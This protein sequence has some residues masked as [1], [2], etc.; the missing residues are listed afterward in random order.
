MSLFPG[1]AASRTLC[2]LAGLC[3]S[4]TV[5]YAQGVPEP[6]PPDEEAITFDQATQTL[7]DELVQFNR[8]AQLA[9]DEFLYPPHSRLSVYISNSVEGFLLQE[10]RVVIDDGAPLV[11][12]YDDRDSRAL[13]KKNALQRLVHVNVERGA[14]RIKADFRGQR[15]DAKEG[16]P[17]LIGNHEAII[18]K[19]VDP[20][21]VELQVVTNKRRRH[22][23]MQV[24]E[25]RTEQ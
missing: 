15:V 8:D 22:P 6:Q 2:A 17:P 11:Y 12:T 25:W 14:H 10:V 9:E 7:K 23:M 13:L 20:A 16:D 5:A 19:T 18:D 4:A 1:L 24:K 3:L 21:E